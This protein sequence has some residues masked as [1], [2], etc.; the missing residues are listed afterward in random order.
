MCSYFCA[1][2]G[3]CYQASQESHAEVN[4]NSGVI[5]RGQSAPPDTSDWEIFVDLPGKERQGKKG[6]WRRKEGKP[7]KGKVEN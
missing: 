2:L 6:K 1:L 4:L 5:A 7:K 3:S